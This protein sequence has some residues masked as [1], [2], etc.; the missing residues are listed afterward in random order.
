MYSQAYSVPVAYLRVVRPGKLLAIPEEC[1]FISVGE[2]HKW[3]SKCI[4]FYFPLGGDTINRMSSDGSSLGFET[5]W[6]DFVRNQN[7]DEEGLDRMETLTQQVNLAGNSS[8]LG[9]NRK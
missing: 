3:R 2:P 9:K 6:K 7:A 1:A 4:S 8:T 5:L